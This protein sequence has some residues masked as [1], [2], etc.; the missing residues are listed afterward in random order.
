MIGVEVL[1]TL[2]IDVH[3]VIGI[4]AAFEAIGVVRVAIVVVGV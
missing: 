4:A 1:S 3:V 2:F